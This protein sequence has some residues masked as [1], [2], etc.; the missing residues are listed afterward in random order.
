MMKI[1]RVELAGAV[2]IA[3]LV[4]VLAGCAAVQV[5]QK[6]EAADTEQLLA[7]AGFKVK[8]ADTP[9]KMAHLQTLTQRKLTIHQRNGK[10]YYV[11]ADALNCKC[12]YVGNEA[13][14]QRFQQLQVERQI[15]AQQRMTAEMNM[16]ANMDWGLYGPW[17]PYW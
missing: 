12:L 1:G 3:V 15:A 14:Y 4:F 9:K 10:N 13:A 6:N 5:V 17:D 8:L 2:M 7:A 11:Y 16:E